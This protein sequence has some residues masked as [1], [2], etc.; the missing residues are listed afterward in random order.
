MKTRDVVLSSP[1]RPA[2]FAFSR[3]IIAIRYRS[4]QNSLLRSRI[5]SRLPTSFSEN[6]Q[7]LGSCIGRGPLI[8]STSMRKN[9][10]SIE[11]SLN[12]SRLSARGFRRDDSF[13]GER[14]ALSVW[15]ELIRLRRGILF[16]I[17]H[18]KKGFRQRRRLTPR[19]DVYS[20]E[21][22]QTC[23]AL[24]PRLQRVEVR[25]LPPT[26]L[27]FDAALAAACID[28]SQHYPPA[29]LARRSRTLIRRA[30]GLPSSD[31]D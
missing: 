31:G 12:C 21:I 6:F 18:S 3:S 25:P 26:S 11:R 22:W 23:K 5:R 30:V 27:P 13:P 4:T 7:L 29:Y 17:V 16:S 10:A 24:L 8:E 19:R 9:T 2:I 1:I 28:G 20:A 15:K 14:R